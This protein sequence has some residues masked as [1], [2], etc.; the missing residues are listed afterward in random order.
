MRSSTS[1][2]HLPHEPG[3]AQEADLFACALGTAASVH[4]ALSCP[5]IAA[6]RVVGVSSISSASRDDG[7]REI[8]NRGIHP[9]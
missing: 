3:F 2:A 6:S 5:V 9:R 8:V 7:V 4:A 1:G